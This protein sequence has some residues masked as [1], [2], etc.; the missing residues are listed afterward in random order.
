MPALD[1]ASATPDGVVERMQRDGYCVV[2]GVL[3]EEE[4]A[5]ARASLRDVLAA[6]PTGRNSFEGFDTQRVYALFA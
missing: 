2:E 6:T 5:A 4:V 1:A 3:G